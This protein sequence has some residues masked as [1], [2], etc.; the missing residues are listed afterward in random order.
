MSIY[1]KS[2]L[3]A[4]NNGLVTVRASIYVDYLID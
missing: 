3:V 1:D 2:K 4:I